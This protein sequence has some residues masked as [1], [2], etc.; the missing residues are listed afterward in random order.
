MKSAVKTNQITWDKTNA[1]GSGASS[2]LETPIKIEM[3]YNRRDFK[4][5]DHGG[6]K[7][8]SGRLSQRPAAEDDPV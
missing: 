2:S 1:A 5:R 3:S 7:A 6:K 4:R 8:Q